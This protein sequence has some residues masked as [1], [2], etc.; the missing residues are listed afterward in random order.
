M[1]NEMYNTR[2]P[3]GVII[4]YDGYK[5]GDIVDVGKHTDS[6]IGWFVK[7]GGKMYLYYE[8]GSML[9]KTEY[10]KNK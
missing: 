4:E 5:M 2:I 3:E 9:L 1:K 6:R 10:T 8:W 7:E